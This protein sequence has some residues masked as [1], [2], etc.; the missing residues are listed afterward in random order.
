MKTVSIISIVY[1]TLG[2]IWAAVVSAAIKL[3]QAIFENFPFPDEVYDYVDIDTLLAAL[4]S[5]IGSLFPYVFIIGIIYILSGILHL[6][7]KTSFRTL[8]S[9]A[10][11]LN[12][13][14]YVA[15]IVFVQVEFVPLINSMDVFPGKL[16]NLMILC[17]MLIN[18]L[19]YCGYP[20]FL[21]LYMRKG[22]EWDT[23]DTGYKS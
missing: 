7:G 21:M 5:M 12:I 11:I 19:F 8:A 20:V 23:L 15:Y 1:G 18:A 9:I 14:W 13:I 4:Y 16:M 3:H 2:L 17:G 10:A 6:A 22:R